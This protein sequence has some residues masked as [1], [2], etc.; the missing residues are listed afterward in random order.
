[1]PEKKIGKVEKVTASRSFLIKLSEPIK[2]DLKN[3]NIY[4]DGKFVAIVRDVI[5]PVKQPYITAKILIDLDEARNYIN[6]EAYI[7]V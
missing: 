1:M 2:R 6:R 7:E 3:R 4:I 5:G